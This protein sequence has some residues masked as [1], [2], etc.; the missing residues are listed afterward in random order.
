MKTGKK[1]AIKKAIQ[2]LSDEKKFYGYVVHQQRKS[3]M[4]DS[5]DWAFSVFQTNQAGDIDS[6][7]SD[8]MDIIAMAKELNIS[9]YISA[10]DYKNY[11]S[12]IE[13]VGRPYI[14]LF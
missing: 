10:D 5:A 4:T 9:F 3:P 1:N 7:I 8:P 2:K 14:R 6:L 13:C 11:N 12:P